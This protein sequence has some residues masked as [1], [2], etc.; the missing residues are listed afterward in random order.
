MPTAPTAKVEAFFRSAS[1]TGMR[2]LISL[3]NC[4]ITEL[5]SCHIVP[6]LVAMPRAFY[7]SVNHQRFP[8]FSDQRCDIG[9]CQSAMSHLNCCAMHWPFSLNSCVHMFWVQCCTWVRSRVG[10]HHPAW[11]HC[12]WNWNC[13]WHHIGDNHCH[14]DT[15]ALI[16]FAELLDQRTL[17]AE[18]CNLNYLPPCWDTFT[19]IKNSKFIPNLFWYP[20]FIYYSQAFSMMKAYLQETL[21]VV[22]LSNWPKSQNCT[23]TFW[24][25]L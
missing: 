3:E 2:Q 19:Y 10:Q 4:W 16:A 23:N 6:V 20:H 22:F 7:A 13:S 17:A 21:I 24:T 8:G 9:T 14:F 18:L 12:L 1:P 25:F 5:K 11:R 15:C